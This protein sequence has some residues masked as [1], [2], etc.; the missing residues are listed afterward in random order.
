M[1]VQRLICYLKALSSTSFICH[2]VSWMFAFLFLSR[3][4]GWGVSVPTVSLQGSATSSNL[5][6]CH[7]IRYQ[8][9]TLSA[10]AVISFAHSVTSVK[11]DKVP[12]EMYFCVLTFGSA[13]H[14]P[15]LLVWLFIWSWTVVHSA[16]P[17]IF[18]R[19]SLKLFILP[20]LTQCCRAAHGHGFSPA[21]GGRCGCLSNTA[22]QCSCSQPDHRAQHCHPS[23]LLSPSH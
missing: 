4:K 23:E 8:G 20:L 19:S 1:L 18:Q 11:C 15:P 6:Y 7:Q 14:F 21:E 17:V 5:Y 13:E 2:S 12:G 9:G 22:Q 16:F 10:C 3:M